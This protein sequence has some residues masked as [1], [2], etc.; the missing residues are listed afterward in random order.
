MKSTVRPSVE[1]DAPGAVLLG[2]RE[3]RAAGGLGEGAGRLPWIAHGDVEVDELAPEQLVP[4]RAADEPRLLAAQHLS[5]ELKH[6]RPPV[7]PVAGRS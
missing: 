2:E 1:H 3:G 7:A 6:R 5:S 4:H